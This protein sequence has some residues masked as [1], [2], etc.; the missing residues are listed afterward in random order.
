MHADK[1]FIGL[2]CWRGY[3]PMPQRAEHLQ[4]ESGHAPD[5]EGNLTVLGMTHP[6]KK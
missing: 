4:R 2:G 5:L 6:F 1:D 3:L